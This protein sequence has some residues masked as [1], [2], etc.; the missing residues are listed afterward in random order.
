MPFPPIQEHSGRNYSASGPGRSGQFNKEE[1]INKDYI[2]VTVPVLCY[3]E[4][5]IMTKATL[6]KEALSLAL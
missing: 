4:T 1:K 2:L 6:I 3:E 5:S